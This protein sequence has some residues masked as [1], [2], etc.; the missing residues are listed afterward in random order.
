MKTKKFLGI[1][2]LLIM[3]FVGKA[4]LAIQPTTAVEMN[5]YLASFTDSLTTKGQEWGTL[6]S[7]AS[8]TRDFSTLKP[9]RRSFETYID[10]SISQIKTLK[11]IA[12]SEDLR[13]ATIAFLTY[14]KTAVKCFTPFENLTASSTSEEIDKLINNLT[15][16]STQEATELKKLAS[17]QQEYARK[18]NFT[19]ESAK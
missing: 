6:L 17:A 10:K 16:F 11:D 4:Q 9:A 19:I 2:I 13:N 3:P 12:G 15:D 14:E 5:N 7:A 18:N 8:S 1:I